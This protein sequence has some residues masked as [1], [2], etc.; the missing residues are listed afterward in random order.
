MNAQSFCR[1][2]GMDLATIE[3]DH[4][5]NYFLKLCEINFRNFGESTHIGGVVIDKDWFWITTHRRVNFELNFKHPPKNDGKNC[6]TLAKNGIKLFQFGR[7]NCFNGEI[8]KFVCQK[9]VKKENS[10]R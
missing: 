9:M 1:S 3:S 8:E 6:L 5:K 10:S 7:T 2:N 4:E